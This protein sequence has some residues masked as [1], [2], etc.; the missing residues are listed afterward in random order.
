MVSRKAGEKALWSSSGKIDSLSTETATLPGTAEKTTAE[1]SKLVLKSPTPAPSHNLSPA[2]KNMP[3]PTKAASPASSKWANLLLPKQKA[4]KVPKM[5]VRAPPA[6]A[7]PDGHFPA[8]TTPPGSRP[9]AATAPSGSRSPR[10]T[11][12]MQQEEAELH[13]VIRGILDSAHQQP[14]QQCPPQQADDPTA[15]SPFSGSGLKRLARVGCALVLVVLIIVLLLAA[16]TLTDRG[17]VIRKQE[18]NYTYPSDLQ[19]R[20]HESGDAFGSAPAPT[21]NGK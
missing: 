6:T 20:H 15:T 7:P 4:E 3:K 10:K 19:E 9:P 5:E 8:A 17:A 14:A 12:S 11:F 16:L 18:V 21:S 1:A 2:A 13:N